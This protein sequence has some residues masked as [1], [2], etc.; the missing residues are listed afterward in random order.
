MK[1][2]LEVARLHDGCSYL[3]DELEKDKSMHKYLPY[4][5]AIEETAD[6]LLVEFQRTYVNG[7]TTAG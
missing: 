7:K 1:Q 4:A 5:R 3:I 2:L 6:Q